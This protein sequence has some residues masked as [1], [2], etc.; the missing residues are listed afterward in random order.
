MLPD[1]SLQ[2]KTKQ[3]IYVDRKEEYMMSILVVIIIVL[4]VRLEQI[5]R[6]F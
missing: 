2:I 4:L 1:E 6:S 5:T 3:I